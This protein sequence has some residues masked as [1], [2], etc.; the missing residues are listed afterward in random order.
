[1]EYCRNV[2]TADTQSSLAFRDRIK[3]LYASCLVCDRE[4]GFHPT[5]PFTLTK[6]CEP[7]AAL[8]LL[9]CHMF[10]RENSNCSI[11]LVQK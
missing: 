4:I 8:S 6:I 2:T 1:M 10:L 9:P 11:S 3:I 7:V 5:N